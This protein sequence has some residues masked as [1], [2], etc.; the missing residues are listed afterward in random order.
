MLNA[1]IVFFS[2]E[3]I[4]RCP[5]DNEDVPFIICVACIHHGGQG[6]ACVS[7]KNV[8]CT[9]EDKKD[10]YCTNRRISGK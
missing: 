8:K 5:I 7:V 6:V 4:G 2:N 10:E 3:G 1:K 9:Y